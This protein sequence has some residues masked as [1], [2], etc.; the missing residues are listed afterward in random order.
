MPSRAEKAWYAAIP[1]NPPPWRKVLMDGAIPHMKQ[2]IRFPWAAFCLTILAHALTE[3]CLADKPAPAKLADDY[4]ASVRPLL[5]K[6]CLDCHSTK[7]HKGDL[8]LER[9]TSLTQIRN[10]LRPWLAV[11][12]MLENGEMPPKESKKPTAEERR[13]L[14][15]WVH[16]MLEVEAR[17]KAGDPGRVVVRR[18]SNAEY[19]NT[20]RD[21]TGVNL[22]PARDFPID[23]A[24]G[25]GFTNAGDALVTS[26][27]LLNKY[28]GAAKEITS[29]VVLLPDGFRFSPA[30][31]RRD[32]TEEVLTE[33]RKFYS[34]FAA[35]GKLPLAPYIVA[36]IRFRDDLQ[37][38]KTTLDV[39]AKKEK[40]NLQYLQVLW[41]AL[42]EN[43]PSFPLGHIQTRWRRAKPEDAS[44][45]LSDIAAWQA[46]LWN[47]VPVGSYRYNNTIRQ[48]PTNPGVAESAPNRFPFKPVPG[49]ND[50]VLYLSAK[51]FT[52]TGDAGRVVWRRPRFEGG[53]KPPQLLRDY[54]Q[55]GPLYEVDYRESFADTPAYLGA[56]FTAA[57]DR[58]QTASGL[59]A[60]HGLDA[61]LLER[62]IEILAVEP[63][64]KGPDGSKESV[65]R[66]PVIPLELLD[67]RQPK[68]EQRPAINGWTPRGAELPSFVSNA[69]DQ[70]EHIPGRVPPHRV[71]VHPSPTRFAGAVWKSPIDGQVR[72]DAKII[73][74]HPG[75]G[76]G[77]AW[78]LEHQHAG[79]SF[80]LGYGAVDIGRD[81]TVRPKE[82]TVSKG[83][84]VLLAIDPRDGSHV[85]D[86]TEISLA[87]TEKGKAERAWDLARDVADTVLA[88]NPHA[89][90]L[91]NPDTWQ[92]VQ[93]PLRQ[94]P[95]S[96]GPGSLVP[97]ESVLGKW[98]MAAADP[99]RQ[100]GLGS[101]AE[102]ARVLLTGNRPAQEKHP[103]RLLYDT[104]VSVESP[105]FQ[106]VDF[107]K[108]KKGRV[109]TQ[110]YGLEPVRFGA[111]NMDSADLAVPSNS[112]VEVRLPAALFRDREFVVEG[113]FD[114]AGPDRVV[115]FQ[116]LA[117]SP[118]ADSPWDGKTPWVARRGSRA[119]ESL[120][121]GLDAFRKCFPTFIC[122][123]HVIPEDETVCLKMFHREDEP[124]QRLFLAEE[125]KKRLDR[126]WSELRFISEWPVVEHKQLPQFIG[127]VTQDQPKELL[128]YFE[129]QREPFRQRAEAFEKEVDAAVPRQ[130]QRLV[131][132]GAMAYR[133]PLQS[134]ESSE[135][136]GLYNSLRK[137]RMSHDEAFRTVLTRM[138]ISPSFL[139][140][141]EQTPPGKEAQLVSSAEMATR[142]S[143][144]LWATMPDVELEGKAT[145]GQLLE[146]KTLSAEAGRM[147]KDPKARGLAI[148]FATQW[149]HVRD[150]EQNRE[151]NEKLFPSFD[152]QLRKALFEETVRFFLDMFQNDRSLREALDADYTFLNETLAKHYG[153]PGVVGKEWR[154]VDGVR[155]YGRG[156]VLTLGSVLTKQSG[157]SR[158]SPILRGNWL[159]EV[160]LGEKLPKPPPTVPMLPEE[161]SSSAETVRKLVEKHTR[162][163]ECIVCHQRIDPFGFALEKYD[164]IGRFRDKDLAG[165]LVDTK[166]RLKDGTQFDG[167]DGLRNYLAKQRWQEFQRHFCQKLLGYALGRS[168]T[169]SD[170]PLLDTMMAEL[171]KNDYRVSAALLTIVQSKQFRYHRGMEATKEE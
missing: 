112:V 26:P 58:N 116:V 157:A 33:L 100:S 47:F 50:V 126:L 20:I 131:E 109:A 106:G 95:F 144:F 23:G 52:S 42:T 151:K 7:K 169:L 146:T 2:W 83:D 118:R 171:K 119:Y 90:K 37:A 25:E 12:E 73:H 101:L 84:L 145:A 61:S 137:K 138:L 6:F 81:T 128:A 161:E 71:A 15:E 133:R 166:V 125:Q 129:S 66:M 3:P 170:Q 24:A 21:L 165:R 113:T 147:L 62:W 35:D 121:G 69:S 134:Q 104:L 149:L 72:V 79:Q 44:A 78:W 155:K 9:F 87:V 127:Y 163:P 59:A 96:R 140:R 139:F 164:P 40:L 117:S 130:L 27:T 98:R 51:N 43:R 76:N 34:N 10:D 31:T 168:V 88:G 105:L 111:E 53:G 17:A 36:S 56:A 148:E 49:Q 103:D 86:L 136:L 5:M 159:V 57:N 32:A 8:D 156:G 108:L 82:I 141:L 13:L 80:I 153:I 65:R 99:A 167:V 142:L 67:W 48:L 54:S 115:Q 132:F 39:V 135:L 110:H 68:N 158:T 22:Q 14:N 28:L 75:C 46:S 16:G 77:V 123:T 160:M 107:A 85:C 38:G 91:G 162:V 93:G 70:V 154:R 29:H 1:V 120:L 19:N 94:L 143:Y 150:I 41:Q 92:F 64:Q 114:F 60:K 18:L 30:K 55:F 122:L 74:A 4:T 89:D 102:Q 152:E 63:L 11:Q 124:L 45:V 97:T